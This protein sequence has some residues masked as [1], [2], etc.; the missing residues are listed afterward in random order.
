ME[1]RRRHEGAH[2]AALRRRDRHVHHIAVRRTRVP[3]RAP[4]LARGHRHAR[5]ERHVEARGRDGVLNHLL[6]GKVR[7]L[8]EEP[9]RAMKT[10][11]HRRRERGP[12]RVASSKTPVDPRGSP[13]GVRH[14]HPA[15]ALVE[16]PAPVVE[17]RPPEGKRARERPAGLRRHPLPVRGIRHEVRADDAHRRAEHAHVVEPHPFAIGRELLIKRLSRRDPLDFNR[18]GVVVIVL[19]RRR[20]TQDGQNHQERPHVHLMPAGLASAVPRAFE[21]AAEG[22]IQI[23]R[24][25]PSL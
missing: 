6:R 12:A 18:L 11:E 9:A 5:V 7:R 15:F 13:H 24:A 23:D 14:P 4:P 8:H 22:L 17:R 19:R 21:R 1:L 10:N 16:P 25:A 20:E 2:R 3:G